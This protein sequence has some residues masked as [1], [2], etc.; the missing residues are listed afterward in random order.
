MGVCYD[1]Q[2]LLFIDGKKYRLGLLHLSLW[3]LLLSCHIC[4][5]EPNTEFSGKRIRFSNC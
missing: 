4:L 2:L 1:L 5:R 3:A